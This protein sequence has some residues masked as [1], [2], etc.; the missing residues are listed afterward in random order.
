MELLPQLRK[1][2]DSMTEISW[3]IVLTAAVM[4]IAGIGLWR[5][6]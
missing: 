3:V 2:G 1:S 4:V 6:K 5:S